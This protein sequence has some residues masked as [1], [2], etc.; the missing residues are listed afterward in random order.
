MSLKE[1]ERLL[2]VVHDLRTKCPWDRKQ[3]H[4][5][6]VPY[7]IEEAYEAVDAIEGNKKRALC[8]E[9]G[10]VL[11]QVALHAEIAS[12]KK[13][14]S[15]EDVARE[16]AD[17]MIRRHPH[18]YAKAK[19]KDYKTH[20]KNWQKLKAEE[21][22]KQKSLLSGVPKVLPALQ[23]SQR[24]G[25]I[26]GSVGFDW[27]TAADVMQKVREEVGELEKEVKRSKR[28]VKNL[29]L[30]FGDMLFS[31]SQIARHLKVDAEAAL[32]KSTEKFAAR[33]GQMEEIQRK[34]GRAL[35]DS[36]KDELEVLWNQV[37]KKK[38]GKS[39]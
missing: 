35:H 10:D 17:K 20:M 3:T 28:D 29:E 23:L 13:N 15:F 16:I 18:I 38:N 6:L 24:Y 9:L 4:K 32:R 1:T 5:T 12:E 21:K 14:F 36:T 37:K 11:L 27:D 26:A 31:L 39:Q 30:E 7:L 34:K 25:E 2:K 33:F 8:E 19:V 22:P